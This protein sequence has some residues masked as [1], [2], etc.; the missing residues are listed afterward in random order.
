MDPKICP[1]DRFKTW[2]SRLDFTNRKT[3]HL[4]GDFRRSFQSR[5]RLGAAFLLL[6]GMTSPCFAGG[7]YVG[8]TAAGD[9]ITYQ[10]VWLASGT[11]RFTARAA[12]TA[13]GAQMHLEVDNVAVSSHMPVPNTGRAD[14]F[15]NVA[16]GSKAI[17]VGYHD[18][19]VYFET[20]NVSLDWFMLRKDTDTSASVKASDVTMLRPPTSGMLLAPVTA[21]G[22]QFEGPTTPSA[23][24][25]QP[26]NDVNGGLY[27]DAQMQAWYSV[28]MYRDFDRR[29]DRYWDVM[30]EQLVASR[31]QVPLFHCRGTVDFTDD[32]QDREYQVAGGAFEG[33]WLK[34]F[35]EAVARNPQAAT[36]LKIGMFWENG[37]IATDFN[38]RYGYFPAWGDPAFAD[39]VMR[40]WLEPWFDSVP[41]DLLYQPFPNR[42]IISVF[43]GRP[44]SVKSDGR[45][46]VFLSEVRSRLLDKYGYDPLFI[47]PVGGD[48]DAATQALGW[49]QAPWVTWNGPLCVLNTFS[50]N[51]TKWATASSG[52]RHRLDNVWLNDWNPATNTGTPGGDSAGADAHQPRLDGSGNSQFWPALSTAQAAGAILVQEE[53]FTNIAEGN[54][55]FRSF[56]PEWAYPN[57]HLD[58]MREYADPTTESLVFEAEACDSYNK[59]TP[60]GNKGGTY[61]K[62]W[63]STGD[64][65]VYRPLTNLQPWVAKTSGP[66]TL[67]QIEAGFYDVWALDSSGFAWAQR[68]GGNPDRWLKV[69]PTQQFSWVSIGKKFAW[70]VSPTGTVYSA[71]RGYPAACNTVNGW[72][73]RSGTNMA[74]LDV[75]ETEVW[76]VNTSGQV[77]RRPVD[78]ATGD[79]VQVTGITLDKVWVGDAFVWGIQGSTIS[80]ARTEGTPSWA[81]VANPNSITQLSLGADEVW[82]VNAAGNIFRRSA[83]GVGGW[84]AVDGTMTKIS[85]GEYAVWGLNGT[86]PSRRKMEGFLTDG[87]ATA[88]APIG[89]RALAGDGRIDLS[90]ISVSGATGYAVKRSTVS[91]GPYTTIYTT[92]NPVFADLGVV[93]GTTYYYVISAL[94]ANGAGANSSEISSAAKA[95]PAAPSGL[96]AASASLTQV[97]LTWTDNA[98]NEAG[99]KVERKTGA[100]GTWAE[101]RRLFG[102]NQTSYSDTTVA[103]GTKYYYRVRAY[104]GGADSGYSNEAN[105]TTTG[106]STIYVNFQPASA[107]A[108]PGYLVDGGLV[109][110]NRGNGY[111]YGWNV[112]NSGQSRDRNLNSDQRLD[113]MVPMPLSG[114]WEFAVPNG[115]YQVKVSVGDVS[116]TY[117]QT[118]NVEGVNYWNGVSVGPACANLT[119]TVT[120][121]DGKLTLNN[122]AGAANATRLDY[123]EI[124]PLSVL[125][126]PTG[127]SATAGNASA[128]LSWT[129][130]Q[131]AASYNVKRAT[132]SG[133]PYSTTVATVL[134]NPAF[135][136]TGLTNGTTYYYVVTAVN[137]NG[138]SVNSAPAS[139]A[140]ANTNIVTY[141]A[142]N[143]LLVGPNVANSPT[144]F[145][146]TGFADYINSSTDYIE[147]TV[148]VGSAGT[149]TLTFRYAASGNRPLELKVNGTVVNSSLAMPSTGGTNIW[150]T[151]SV[152]GVSVN[153]GANTIRLT[154]TGSSGNNVDSL[155]LTLNGAQSPGTPTGLAADAGNTQATLSWA[156]SPGATGYSVKRATVSGGPYTEVGTPSGTTFT[157][158]G[159]TAGTTYY[160]VVAAAVS[161]SWSG[162]STEVAVTPRSATTSAPS[163]VSATPGNAQVALTWTA[164]SGAVA[165]SI[166]RSTTS[167]SGYVTIGT[168][169]SAGFTDT[170]VLNGQTYYYVVSAVNTGGESANSTQV[171][172]LPV[173]PPPV[174]AGVAATP[175]NASVLTGWTASFGATSYKVKRATVSGGPYTQV[176]TPATNSFNNTGLTNATTY[177]YVVSAV[178]PNGESANSAQV[179]ATPQAAPAAPTNLLGTSA[180]GSSAISWTASTLATSYNVKRSTTSGS[181]YTTVGSGV[182]GT[183]FTDTGLTDGTVYY[184]VVT[185]V[186]VGGES[187]NSTQLCVM[188]GTVPSPWTVTNIDVATGG[189]VNFVSPT[190]TVQATGR[191]VGG[192]GAADQLLFVNQAASGDC[193]IEAKIVS[194]ENTNEW[195]K[196]GVMIR[197]NLTGGS[198]NAAVL[199]TPLH[200]VIFQNRAT[201]AAATNTTSTTTGLTVPYWVKVT[202]VGNTFTGYRSADGITWTQMGAA[203]TVTMATNVYIGFFGS[204]HITNGWGQSTFTNVTATP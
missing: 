90:W 184:Y 109:Y 161:G 185:G 26:T 201:S 98:T 148:N 56:H 55:I 183:S 93:N 29:T 131:F 133:G 170:G 19:K 103:S 30:V 159:L 61:R 200:G 71:S 53:G 49:G 115:S 67:T 172:A 130:V 127:L 77:F 37:G 186:G 44:T 124:T 119:N 123:V 95:A 152:S 178:G 145:T 114:V 94:N 116:G 84:D 42:P 106:G 188:P 33:R 111:S 69:S 88:A 153:A 147:W 194:G 62:Q 191:E 13:S 16:L 63:Y 31:A 68:L 121:S 112:D 9:S 87:T 78:P 190:Y 22:H 47:L 7:W 165:Y 113:T 91:G 54:S 65:D 105:A 43:S 2:S 80:F 199:V 83:S 18:I 50:V 189:G 6:T 58:V 180:S 169:T 122:G 27:T 193:S 35:S 76:G 155:I 146:G 85:V 101:V 156:A 25:G 107:P 51:G 176:G 140:P 96:S 174:P 126:A 72:T 97:D 74:Q 163:G 86:T 179:A 149:A 197:E 14:Q 20:A 32:L 64:L 135:T 23:L 15:T 70:G 8:N 164:T 134:T 28:P 138:E 203:Q 110:A 52:S 158:T 60:S 108:V 177:Y 154:A 175:G 21:F 151:V 92:P 128:T 157:N 192:A 143:A 171:S 118:L 166:K 99:F 66:G 136:D 160:Y 10:H 132:T 48:V 137:A 162:N 202:R 41:P 187:V 102:A 73:L 39:Y 117:V 12:A 82:G 79:W 36:S 59:I 46:S 3:P 150:G 181:G 100:S 144:G 75:G 167:G 11:Y 182:T 168:A 1:L 204:S 125:P 173:G 57:Q 142:E 141:E 129:P 120:V 5:A 104:A 45:M 89:L 198:I 196:W 139:V 17:S 40:Y 195:A 38:A 34:K 4:A 81:T 24:T